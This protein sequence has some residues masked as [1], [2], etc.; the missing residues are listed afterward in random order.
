MKEQQKNQQFLILTDLKTSRI[1]HL[2]DTARFY[3][4]DDLLSDDSCFYKTCLHPE[5]YSVY[6]D[7]L[8]KIQGEQ[9]KKIKLRVKNREGNWSEFMFSDRLY[10]AGTDDPA[11]LTVACPISETKKR[12]ESGED[13]SYNSLKDEYENLINSL[14]EGF[15]IVE[16]IYNEKGEP[17]DYLYMKTNP[18]FGNMSIFRM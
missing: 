4:G 2:N 12:V 18:A 10:H 5:D 16:M 14:D 6:L 17:E 15:C 11:V 1:K 3:G 8:S 13:P 7:H 9:Q